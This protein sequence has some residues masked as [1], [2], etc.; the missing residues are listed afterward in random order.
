M[1]DARSAQDWLLSSMLVLQECT[2]SGRWVSE[3]VGRSERPELG[4]AKVVV[5]GGRALKSA[6][7]FAMLETLADKLGGAVGASRA[8]VDAGYV[9]NS[10]Q[11]CN[12]DPPPHV[13]F[14]RN[15]KLTTTNCW[16]T[17]WANWKGGSP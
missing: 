6:E 2:C 10:L 7:K 15:W 12:C 9:P 14:N 3:E 11:V 4:Q 8:A 13:K 1:C 5:A 17:G 16:S